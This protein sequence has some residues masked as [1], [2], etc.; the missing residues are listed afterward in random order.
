MTENSGSVGGRKLLIGAVV[1]SGA[2]I[3]AIAVGYVNQVTP[4][5][6]ALTD[7]VSGA[8]MDDMDGG[9]AGPAQQ[10]EVEHATG[11]VPMTEL[12]TISLGSGVPLPAE[13]EPP[14]SA[15]PIPEEIQVAAADTT[16]WRIQLFSLSS[17]TNTETAWTRLQ[18]TNPDLL[19]NLTLH[20][21]PAE[22]SNG[23]F[24]R[25]QAGPVLDRV[26]A[27]SLCNELKSRNQDCLVVA[28]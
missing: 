16:A 23:T 24:Y 19:D 15:T 18:Q 14:L 27:I 28:P 1:L 8:D 3:A 2:V 25:V 7:P 6:L 21:Q 20:V 26:A 5:N 12:A 17:Q 9:F 4:L 10:T 22:L 11:S 13:I